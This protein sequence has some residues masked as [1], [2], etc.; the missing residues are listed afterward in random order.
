MSQ[1]GHGMI[2]SAVEPYVIVSTIPTTLRALTVKQLSGTFCMQNSI[3]FRGL[4]ATQ[5]DGGA[6]G[7]A[8]D[9]PVHLLTMLASGFVV[10]K[11]LNGKGEHLICMDLQK[12]TIR[13][14]HSRME[15]EKF[16]TSMNVNKRERGY[17]EDGDSENGPAKQVKEGKSRQVPSDDKVLKLAIKE[18]RGDKV[19]GLY[20][21]DSRFV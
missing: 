2:S 20:E 1:T 4:R 15:K 5:W 7:F 17:A 6:T 21:K 9:Q 14:T 11:V 8:I 3:P 10:L 12:E 19:L 16:L 18:F 13:E